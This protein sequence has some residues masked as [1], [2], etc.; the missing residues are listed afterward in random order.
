M[1]CTKCKTTA[2]CGCND[3]ALTNP[4]GYTACGDGNERCD[5]IQCT[6]CVSYCGTSF[7]I[8]TVGGTL[9]IETGERLDLIIQ[10]MSLMIANGLGV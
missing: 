9:K 7:Q 4:C 2:D 3:T 8:P 1:A 10:K 5:D 6:E